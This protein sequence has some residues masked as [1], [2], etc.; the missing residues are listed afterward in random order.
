[1]NDMLKTRGM[2]AKLNIS[3][4]TLLRWAMDG[5]VPFIRVSERTL[6]FDPVAVRNALERRQTA[7]G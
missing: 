2:A 1:M 5:K 7:Y 4:K 6:L 3:P